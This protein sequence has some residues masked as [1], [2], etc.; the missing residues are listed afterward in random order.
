MA[1]L[2]HKSASVLQIDGTRVVIIGG[3]SGIDLG[4][5]RLVLADAGL[6]DA[7]RVRQPALFRP[8]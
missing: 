5:A 6:P 7:H 1:E 8:A 2:S 3:R 4:T